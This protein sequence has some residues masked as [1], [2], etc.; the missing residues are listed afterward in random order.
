MLGMKTKLAINTLK[1]PADW[2]IAFLK[3]AEARDISLSEWVGQ[4]CREKLLPKE[5]RKL[6]PFPKDRY[7]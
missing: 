2:W 5:R 4:C 1:L 3:E 6:S 7:R